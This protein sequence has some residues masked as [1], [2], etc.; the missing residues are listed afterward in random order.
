LDEKGKKGIN[1]LAK[2][3]QKLQRGIRI[4]GTRIHVSIGISRTWGYPK[5][6]AESYGPRL[7]SDS[8]LFP[9]HLKICYLDIG[10]RGDV[11]PPWSLFKQNQIRVIGFEPDKVE[12]QRLKDT[13]PERTYFPYA[14]WNNNRPGSFFLNRDESTSSMF[15]SNAAHISQYQPKHWE[16]RVTTRKLRIPRRRLDSILNIADWPDFMKIDTQGSE[17][18]ILEGASTILKNSAPIILAETWCDEVYRGAPM[19][20]DVMKLMWDYG[21]QVFDLNIA[22][23]WQHGNSLGMSF[24]CKSKLVGL[25]LLFV[26]RFEFLKDI[27]EEKLII[28]IGLLEL[29]GFADYAFYIA[30]NHHN[31]SSGLKEKI[32]AALIANNQVNTFAS[33]PALH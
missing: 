20:H 16:S 10:A 8:N 29:Y 31:I 18:A 5:T 24:R 30:S 22:A 26:K 21:Y 23:A 4:P 28:L 33:F 32:R 15:P 25:D 9:D 6:F 12:C 11:A 27:S 3:R 14:A 13:F 1:M 19:S 2:L 7:I 17:Y